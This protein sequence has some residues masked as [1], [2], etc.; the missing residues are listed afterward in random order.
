LNTITRTEYGV[1]IAK[2]LVGA[3]RAFT[4]A[5]IGLEGLDKHL[6]PLIV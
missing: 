4:L 3:G 5:S 1:S 2:I 6:N